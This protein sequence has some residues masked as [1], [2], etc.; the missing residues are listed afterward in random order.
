MAALKY[1]IWKA[2]CGRCKGARRI[3]ERSWLC[4]RGL[5]KR[6][7]HLSLMC[8]LLTLNLSL[9][10]FRVWNAQSPRG[11]RNPH[12]AAHQDLELGCAQ[13]SPPESLGVDTTV[14]STLNWEHLQSNPLT[15]NV[16]A[17]RSWYSW[18][19]SCINRSQEQH[20]VVFPLHP[21]SQMRKLSGIKRLTKRPRINQWNS[22][23]L[24]L[25]F[26]SLKHPTF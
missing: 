5:L 22:W 25:N 15:V 6:G 20:H 17:E 26:F 2:S 4:L 1:F 19:A 10:F 14:T 9:L 12:A 8:R 16:P 18:G 23:N 11:P 13:G 21:I 24:N 7:F 3:L